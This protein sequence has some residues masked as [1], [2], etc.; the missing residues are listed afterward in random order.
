MAAKWATFWG[1]VVVGA[2]A[3]GFLFATF[4]ED[5]GTRGGGGGSGGGGGGGGG[6][7]K[8]RPQGAT[9]RRGPPESTLAAP[10]KDST[11]AGAAASRVDV[12]RTI[13]PTFS[14]A[15][16]CTR[17]HPVPLDYTS[18]GVI[19]S[20]FPSCRGTPRQGFLM[21]SAPATL[22][23]HSDIPADTIDGLAGYSHVWVLFHFHR[24]RASRKQAG[25]QSRKHRNESTEDSNSQKNKPISFKQA[26][27]IAKRR[28]PR[29][30]AKINPPKLPSGKVGVFSA[31]T[32]HRP[33]AIGLTLC[34]LESVDMM[35]RR[36]LLSGV[37]LVE[38]TPVVDIKPYVPHY[39]SIPSA[40]VPEWVQNSLAAPMLD[41]VIEPS[42][43]AVMAEEVALVVG[44]GGFNSSSNKKKT[45]KKEVG[46][47]RVYNSVDALER[48]VTE[49]LRL[50]INSGRTSNKVK[51]R[52]E[53]DV[54]E[55]AAVRIFY[56]VLDGLKFECHWQQQSS[57]RAVRVVDV[58]R[59]RA[60][61]SGKV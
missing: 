43:R 6:G 57:T 17:T 37:D 26:A 11:T 5:L 50:D 49:M 36:L 3:S 2:A 9:S 16:L 60:Q 29:F 22:W 61:D 10:E 7:G 25:S 39:D 8:E 34:R 33:N 14:A 1:G 53:G 13:V 20:C 54:E 18:V 48:A 46:A 58:T 19:E 52:G 30:K 59:A 4:F 15:R 41:V 32:P 55:S 56:T 24:N 21:P 28:R 12:G 40:A 27:G 23:L 45:T 31:R 42:A 47:L 51:R 38:G 44:A 35:N